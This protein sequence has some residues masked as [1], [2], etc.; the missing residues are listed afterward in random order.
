MR[1]EPIFNLPSSPVIPGKAIV[2]ERQT[3]DYGEN[4]SVDQGP[5]RIERADENDAYGYIHRT[6]S[7]V[8]L[9]KTDADAD[10]CN[11]YQQSGNSQQYYERGHW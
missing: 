4:L 1:L 5:K 2:A 9:Q 7:P 11:A 10:Q 8:V 3:A 6:S